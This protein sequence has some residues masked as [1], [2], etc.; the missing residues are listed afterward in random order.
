MSNFRQFGRA[1][2]FLLSPSLDEWLPERHLARL[3]VEVI[4]GLN[5][6]AMV[7]SYR[8]NGSASYH[9]RYCWGCWCTAT[10]RGCFRAASWNERPTTS[11]V[12]RACLNPGLGP[13][14]CLV[15]LQTE[16][17]K[18]ISLPRWDLESS[19]QAD[20]LLARLRP[21]RQ[22][23]SRIFEVVTALSRTVAMTTRSGT[24]SNGSL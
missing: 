17:P 16:V 1:T 23:I 2:G 6:S 12:L 9:P 8:G 22:R 15:H 14:S 3:V 20:V 21:R 19:S 10:R 4:D 5:L 7:K 11:R 24:H 13:P 18:K